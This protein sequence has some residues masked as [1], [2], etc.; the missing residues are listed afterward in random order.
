MN[1]ATDLLPLPLNLIGWGLWVLILGWALWVAPWYKV[2]TDASA[3]RVFLVTTILIML[4]WR[5][6]ASLASGLSFHFLGMTVVALMFGWQFAVVLASLAVL[7]LTVLG[8]LGADAMGWNV[9]LMGIVPASLAWGSWWLAYRYMPRHFFVY[10]F[11]NGFLVSALSMVVV[12]LMS[13]VV[14]AQSPLLSEFAIW[15]QYVPMLPMMAAP[16]A[17]VNG[18]VITVLVMYRPEWLSTFWDADYLHGK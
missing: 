9:V 5:F 14:L 7:G 18:F 12:V 4:L 3:Q 16:E 13:A 15:Q 8:D 2:K 11:V 10:T 1:I 17:F 6:D